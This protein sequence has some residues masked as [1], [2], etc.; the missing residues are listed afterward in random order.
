VASRTRKQPPSPPRRLSGEDAIFVH[1]ET[2]STPMHTLG[3]LI[4]DPSTVPGGRFDRA[5]VIRHVK[6][7]VHRLPPFRQR[8]IETPLGLGSPVL[9]DDP[10]FRVEKHVHRLRVREPGTLRELAEIVARIAAERLDRSRPL[11][12]MWLVEGLEHGRCALVTKLHHCMIDG[13]TGASQM[14]DLLDFTADAESAKAPRFRPARL[15]SGLA[16]ALG[17]LTRLRDPRELARLAQATAAEVLERVRAGGVKSLLPAAPRTPWSGAL[18]TNRRVAFASAPLED[19]KR[20]KSAFGVTVNDAVLAACTLMLRR[21]LAAHDALPEEPLVCAVPVSI[22]SDEELRQFSNK[23]TLM[24]VRLP[25]QLADPT[26]IVATVHEEAEGAKQAFQASDPELLLGWLDWAP[27]RIVAAASWL[28]TALELADR[29]RM[30]WNCVISNMRGA[31]FPLYFAGAQVLATYPMGPAGDGVGLNITVLSNMGR[32]DFGVLAGGE[33][34]DVW[35]LAGG[36][37]RAVAE[38]R[39]IAESRQPRA[40]GGVA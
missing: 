24:N 3:T 14:A 35:E 13:A 17:A 21:Y 36:F 19:I 40:A 1:A 33:V 11:W 30:P 8:L 18:G 20:V 31:P 28:F 26:A 39:A 2:A 16:L 32:L 12:E 15:P 23:V 37:T 38:L 7:R 9:A 27:G 5:H 4:L 10:E 34:V 29:V 22:K 25:T 6:R